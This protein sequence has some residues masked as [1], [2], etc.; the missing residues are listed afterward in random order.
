MNPTQSR[1]EAKAQKVGRVVCKRSAS[2]LRAALLE[3]LNA[4]KRQRTAALQNLA[5]RPG[6][7]SGA[8]AS[9]SAAVLCRFGIASIRGSIF[10]G[11]GI[12]LNAALLPAYAGTTSCALPQPEPGEEFSGGA[13]TVFDTSPKAFGFPAANLQEDHRA[14]FFVGHSF[15][16]ENWVSLRPR[17]PQ[18][19]ASARSLTLAPARRAI[20]AMAAAAHPNLATRW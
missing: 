10:L 9:W 11:A 17:P 14:A 5:A 19:T 7:K 12:W 18:E 4:K 8:T 2:R 16:N 13:T 15:F 20:C 1:K 6:V 3:F